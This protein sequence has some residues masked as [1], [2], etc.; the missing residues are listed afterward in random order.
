MERPQ[1]GQCARAH[2]SSCCPQ[3]QS[4]DRLRCARDS[5]AGLMFVLVSVR[6]TSLIS[7]ITLVFTKVTHETPTYDAETPGIAQTD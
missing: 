7:Q 3:R 2:R 4:V 5:I 1:R 6:V